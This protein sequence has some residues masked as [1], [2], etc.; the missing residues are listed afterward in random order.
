[1]QKQVLSTRML[2]EQRESHRNK[3]AS[4]AAHRANI[5]IRMASNPELADR[6]RGELIRLD[7]DDMCLKAL[8]DGVESQ[9]NDAP[10]H[11]AKFREVNTTA[12]NNLSRA[13]DLINS[14]SLIIKS[15]VPQLQA[16][17]DTLKTCEQ[18]SNELF[19]LVASAAYALG[20]DVH[21]HEAVDLKAHH[22]GI[23]SSLET[24]LWKAG[25]GQV[26]IYL[27]QITPNNVSDT[28]IEQAVDR[29]TDG[30]RAA[31][32]RLRRAVDHG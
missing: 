24:L 31:I 3:I 14:R 27:P 21:G 8:L 9:L 32:E 13:E 23:S 15:L 18:Q 7:Q 1:M 10:M 30:S 17:G 29:V 19:K 20:I 26:G 25:I 11:E 2:N 28:P 4:N 12:A 22:T 16:I 5:G 6:L